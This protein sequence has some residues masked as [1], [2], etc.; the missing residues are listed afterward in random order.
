MREVETELGN[1][2]SDIFAEN[3]ELDVAFIGSGSIRSKELGPVVTL[4]DLKQTFPYDD[5]YSRYLVDGAK[6][7]KIFAHIMRKSN[8]N[9]EGECFQVNN[10]VKAVF[11]DSQNKLISLK[12]N[13]VEVDDEQEFKIGIQSYH[14]NN[15]QKN[16][17]ISE[18]ELSMIARPKV[19]VSS[20]LAVLDEYLRHHQNLN[21]AVEGRLVYKQVS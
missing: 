17:N 15:C 1:L 16:L 13:G 6:L 14:Y 8:R 4:G 21:A 3:A 9:S 7:R 10:S 18:E 19:M 2:I 11:D 12:I 20:M 5:S